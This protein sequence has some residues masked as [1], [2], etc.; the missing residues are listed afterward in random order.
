MKLLDDK[1][2]SEGIVLPNN[3]LKVDGFLKPQVD[4]QLM[5]EIGKEHGRLFKKQKEKNILRNE[6]SGMAAAVMAGLAMDVKVVIARKDKR[7]SITN[8]LYT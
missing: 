1:I 4:E 8:N 7:L 3:V 2:K 5:D 6:S